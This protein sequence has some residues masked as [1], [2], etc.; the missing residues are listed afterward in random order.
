[1]KWAIENGDHP[2]LRIALCGYEG[3]YQMPDGWQKVSWKAAG[4]YG[5]QGNGNGRV[6][7]GREVIWFSPHCLQ[8]A[9]ALDQMEIAWT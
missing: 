5:S 3:N 9:T 6:N 2:D 1:M 7:A 8:P 4:G